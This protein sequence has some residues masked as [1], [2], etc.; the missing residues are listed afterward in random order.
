MGNSRQIALSIA[1]EHSKIAKGKYKNKKVVK[2]Q[3]GGT[4]TI[5]EYGPRQVA[6][7]NKAKAERVEGLRKN[8]EKLRKQ[9]FSDLENPAALAVALMDATYERIGNDASAKEGHVGVTGWKPEHVTFK[10]GK[11]ILTYVG[12][13]GVEQRKEVEDKRLVKALRKACDDDSCEY[14]V[15]VKPKDVNAYL[16]PFDVTAKDLR[17]FH[18]NREMQERLREA[19][20]NGP[21]LPKSRKE[22]DRILKEEFKKA[23]EETADR[24][25]H[26][27]ATLKGQYL[28]PGMEK[29]YLHDGSV[30]DSLVKKSSAKVLSLEEE[31]PYGRV[32]R[33][34]GSKD[35][36]V[37]F[38]PLSRAKQILSEGKLLM[39]PPYPKFGTD[40]VNAVSLSY[41][42]YV[43]SVQTN[44]IKTGPQDPVVG[45]VFKTSSKPWTG[46]SEEVIWKR[47]VPFQ[48]P[49]KIVSKSKAIGMLRNTSEQ[50]SGDDTVKYAGRQE[51]DTYDREEEQVEKMVRKSPKKKPPRQDLRNNKPLKER[52]RD[53]EGLG[54]QDGGDNDLQKDI[55]RANRVCF[56]WLALR[57]KVSP[58]RLAMRFLAKSETTHKPGDVWKSEESG[59]WVAMNPNEATQSFDEKERAET[60]A[61]GGE[62]SE[63]EEPPKKEESK[64]D[65]ERAERDIIDR[66]VDRAQSVVKDLLG[67]EGSIDDAVL[68]S[69]REAL[70][71]LDD[72]EQQKFALEL[73]S[74]L[75]HLISQD[76]TDPSLRS[77]AVKAMGFE[78]YDGLRDPKEL[79]RKVADLVFAKKVVANPNLLGGKRISGDK[80]TPEELEKRSQ[81]AL[82]HYKEL[83]S[84]MRKSAAAQLE[85][86]LNSV[87]PKSNRAKEMKAILN[88]IAVA[89]IAKTGKSVGNMPEPSKGMATMIKKLVEQGNGGLMFKPAESFF[90]PD[91]QA[92]VLGAMRE[93]A[94]KE[95]AELMGAD[96]PDSPYHEMAQTLTGDTPVPFPFDEG[97]KDYLIEQHIQD[98]TWNDRLI[99]DAMEASGDEDAQSEEARQELLREVRKEASTALYD[100]YESCIKAIQKAKAEGRKPDRDALECAQSFQESEKALL[101]AENTKMLLEALESRG[102]EIPDSPSVG[103]LKKFAETGDRKLLQLRTNPDPETFSGKTA[104]LSRF[105]PYMA[106]LSK[107]RAV[108]QHHRLHLG[109]Q[110]SMRKISKKGAQ[111]V[112]ADIDKIADLIEG[113][114]TDL[115]IPEHIA[116]DLS[117]RLDVLSSHI[118]VQAGLDVE[119]N[120]TEEKLEAGEFDPAHIGDEQATTLEAQPDEPY[121]K[122]FTQDEFDQLRTMQERGEFSNAKA[123]ASLVA[124]LAGRLF[125][126]EE[127][128]EEDKEEGKEEGKE[129]KE[130]SKK[131]CSYDIFE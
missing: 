113:H 75:D 112:T 55:R 116:N 19:R 31:S 49:A 70:R 117:R 114:Y 108:S 97:I 2:T 12:K 4:A 16:K 127:D 44:H 1:W 60:F 95:V 98:I 87:D 71:G 110:S 105:S 24:V 66:N 3:D 73:K 78:G 109:D 111:Q 119:A 59:R 13:S 123:A 35:T 5:Y 53:L 99:R 125:V 94:P 96:S 46:Y 25:G 64:A 91:S 67:S 107:C 40:A 58:V 61:K 11:A 126:A 29:G 69:V 14:L 65:A 122:A 93:M 68:D 42:S 79:G 9:V 32:F 52:D 128:K 43:P 90:T 81:E 76:P 17:G 38:T 103:I 57:E 7:R 101:Q 45:V 34:D 121:M 54:K 15:S 27:P 85:Q 36:F 51:K 23:L 102:L 88:G 72:A 106:V 83:N 129:D 28:V 92:M 131:A 50:I 115:N 62:E 48:G 26:K 10:N 124:K 86:E 41:G 56:R 22:K 47:D 74:S 33:G 37:H 21:A 104:G 6:N 80:K 8:I 20:K 100:E 39:R 30:E 89:E 130:S 118:E 84:D 77:K 82:D 63:K 120:Y 18:A